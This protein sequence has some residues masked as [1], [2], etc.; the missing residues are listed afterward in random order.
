MVQVKHMV[1][2][3]LRGIPQCILVTCSIPLKGMVY[4]G[5][6]VVYDV[7]THRCTHVEP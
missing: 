5:A 2:V 1:T 7:H 3:V 6:G 4:T